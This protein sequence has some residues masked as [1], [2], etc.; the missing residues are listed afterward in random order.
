MCLNYLHSSKHGGFAGSRFGWA[1][2]KD[3]ELASSMWNIA[4]SMILS[5][6]VDIELRILT[7]MQAVLSKFTWISP[8]QVSR[9]H[10]DPLLLLILHSSIALQVRDK[11]IMDCFPCTSLGVI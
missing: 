8:F 9:N 11:V 1:L 3:A 7:A 4:S 5:L 10:V 2:V 6:S